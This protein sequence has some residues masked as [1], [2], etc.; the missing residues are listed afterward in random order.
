V[1]DG[2]RA[3]ALRASRKNGNRQPREVGCWGDLLEYTGDLGGE[4][5]SGL[6]G[7]DLG[8]SALPWRGVNCSLPPVEGQ[9][10]KGLFPYK[11]YHIPHNK[12]ARH[13][14]LSFGN[15]AGIIWSTL[16]F[17]QYLI[18]YACICNL[19]FWSMCLCVCLLLSMCTMCVWYP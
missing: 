7:R 19:K 15:S 18:S 13:W 5:L 2:G 11:I 17:T 12:H 6:K 9:D 16:Y 14:F 4:R 8:W 1:G 10:T 3:E